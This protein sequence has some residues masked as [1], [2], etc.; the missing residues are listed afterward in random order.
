MSSS[1]SSSYQSSS[2]FSRCKSRRRVE[3]IHPSKSRARIRQSRFAF[4]SSRR[5]VRRHPWLMYA[6]KF[7]NFKPRTSSGVHPP[8]ALRRVGPPIF[9]R[10]E[11][12]RN[13]IKYPPSV[14]AFGF[15]FPSSRAR[16]V[17][18]ACPSSRIRSKTHP[19][20]FNFVVSLVVG[21]VVVIVVTSRWVCFPFP[22]TLVGDF[23]PPRD[24]RFPVVVVAVGFPRRAGIA[25]SCVC[26]RLCGRRLFV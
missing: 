6:F 20:K 3:V 18:H 5:S 12:K 23:F 14:S 26:V 22:P 11:T 4:A 2:S 16:G 21:I 24:A 10:N 7:S 9:L 13:K 1:S 17:V 15:R 25:R 19:S 8:L